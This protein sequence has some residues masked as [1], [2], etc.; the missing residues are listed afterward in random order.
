MPAERLASVTDLLR[1]WSGIL[2][3]GVAVFRHFSGS[4]QPAPYASIISAA[5]RRKRKP[6]KDCSRRAHI[7]APRWYIRS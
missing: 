6:A 3:S 2:I 4:M 1:R 5:P 7:I